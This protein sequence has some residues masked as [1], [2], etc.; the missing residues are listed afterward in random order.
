MSWSPSC[1]LCGK[2]FEEP[3][4]VV[5]CP[6]T[7]ELPEN[8]AKWHFCVACFQDF[9]L[10]W[11][12]GME[13]VAPSG[14]T[15]DWERGYGYGWFDFK[16]RGRVGGIADSGQ[17]E[18]TMWRNGYKN[19]WHDA[20]EGNPHFVREK[21]KK[22]SLGSLR[23]CPRC[24]GERF[25]CDAHRVGCSH[26]N[27]PANRRPC[28]AC[29]NPSKTCNYDPT[30]SEVRGNPYSGRC[31]LGTPHCTLLHPRPKPPQET[32]EKIEQASQVIFDVQ[33]K[34]E[35]VAQAIFEHLPLEEY[36][37]MTGGRRK[38]W[39]TDAPWDSNPNELTEHAR[40]DYRSMAK[41]AI[42]AMQR[43]S[44]VKP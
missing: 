26:P 23:V 11:G 3:G 44:E 28:P 16:K 32:L 24:D 22:D 19:G 39:K 21:A 29:N 30:A 8:P 33:E 20:K 15:Q 34:V 40:E 42:L 2:T 12:L 7:P 43:N 27:C 4:A 18:S 25:E 41:A 38:L 35:R 37:V 6:P 13:A 14:S 1:K 17:T 9:L 10:K 31:N 5:I 36:E